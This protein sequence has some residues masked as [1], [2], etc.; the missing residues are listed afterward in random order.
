MLIKYPI[1]KIPTNLVV[2]KYKYACPIVANSI[3]IFLC[4][5][6]TNYKQRD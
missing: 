6:Q 1:M 4:V 2:V 5:N 3:V